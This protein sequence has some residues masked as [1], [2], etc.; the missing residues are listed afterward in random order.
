MISRIG[1]TVFCTLV[2]GWQYFTVS[3]ANCTGC[4]DSLAAIVDG[5]Q[6]YPFVHRLLTPYIIVS[7][8]NTPPVLLAFHLVM[9]SVFFWLLWSW[10]ERFGGDGFRAVTL[11]AVALAVMWP[12]WFYTA[13]TITEWVLWLSGLLL[14]TRRWSSSAQPTAK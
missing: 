6:V 11:V 12:T 5:D 13:Y 8:G 1:V 4:N 7:L 3:L 14:L 10:V 9:L 2:A